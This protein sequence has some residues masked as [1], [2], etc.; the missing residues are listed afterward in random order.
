M[1]IPAGKQFVISRVGDGYVYQNEAG[2][3]GFAARLAQ[4]ARFESHTEARTVIDK[5]FRGLRG[6]LVISAVPA[7]PGPAQG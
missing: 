1:N 7:L 6:R 2:V 3:W 5:F 4:A